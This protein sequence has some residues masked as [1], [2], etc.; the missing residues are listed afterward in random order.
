MKIF[1]MMAAA[2]FAGAAFASPP[3]P[4][5]DLT[6]LDLADKAPTETG[7]TGDWQV[8]LEGAVVRAEPR[9]G[10]RSYN[11]QRATLDVRFDKVIAPGLRAVVSNRL[12]VFGRRTE[13]GHHPVNTLKEASLTWQPSPDRI[14]DFGRINVRQGVATG[15]NPT[16]YF[17]FNAVRA[18]TSADPDTLRKNRLGTVMLRGQMLWS[19]GSLSAL[20]SPKL[21]SK[22]SGDPFDLDFGATN[23]QHRWMFA[24]SQKFS[25]RIAPQFL[26]YGEKGAS[27]QLGMNLT[28][29]LNDATVMNIEWS[30]GRSPTWQAEMADVKAPEHYANKVAAG[31]TYTAP[32]KLSLTVEYAYNGWAPDHDGW[33]ALRASPLAHYTKYRTLMRDR[34]DLPTRHALFFY[35]TWQDAG[36]RH[37]DLTLMRRYNKD[38][39]SGLAWLE[40]RYHWKRADLALQLQYNH[41]DYRSEY[42]VLPDRRRWQAVSTWYF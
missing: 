5:T 1:V 29:L 15:Y 39:R 27:P 14:V 31:V 2:A 30:G 26:L 38:D 40:A 8:V 37:L 23:G 36:L 25:E 12:D 9:N 4:D 22:P 11:D 20:V 3:E 17:K 32:S 35:G 19:T 21:G 42:G 18:I 7:K 13:A 16:D 34:L 41:G 10:S 24:L 6:A 28:T 33:T